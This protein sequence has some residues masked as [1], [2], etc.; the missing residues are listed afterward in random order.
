T[1]DD[2]RERCRQIRAAATALDAQAAILGDL[3]GPKIRIAGFADGPVTLRAG[4]PFTLDAGLGK[5]AGD[6]RRVGVTYPALVDDCRPGQV[7]LLDDGRLE[8]EI[9]RASC[10]ERV[11]SS[12]VA[13]SQK[14]KNQV[15]V[16]G[17]R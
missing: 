8:L 6:A 15:V 11:E 16:T 2:H 3:Q 14:S 1:A 4:E 7:L 9:G 17:T 12:V 10:R 5:L 13:V